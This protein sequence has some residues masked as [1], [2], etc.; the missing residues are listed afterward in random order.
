MR[1]TLKATLGI[2]LLVG[3]L[4]A[5]SLMA[6]ET[7]ASIRGVVVDISD[8]PVAN[9]KVELL[10]QRTG[11]LRTY[12]TN[13]E[14]V[15]LATRLSP[16]G[17][18]TVIV[19]DLATVSIESISVADTYN[20]KIN[21]DAITDVVTVTASRD[22]VE[23]ATGPAA[24]F[25][26]FEVETAVAFNRDIVDI[27]GIDPRIN[28][29]NE[30]DGFA[31]NCA[32]KHPRFN[33]VTLDGVSQ[34]DRFGLNENGYST[35][36]GMPFPYDAIG[37]L[38]VELAPADVTYGG[39]SAC[40]INAVTKS[41]TNEWRGNVFWDHTDDGL[42]GD[43][44][45]GSSN[46]F[47]TPPF[48]ADKYG[49]T[50]GGRIL[51]DKLHFFSALESNESPRF[52]ARGP[53][54]S[55]IGE[56][57]E[58][59]SQADH[60]RIVAIANDVY[61]YDP[62]GDPRDGAQEQDKYMV[63]FDWGI[64]PSHNA[65]L[66]YNYY[67]GFQDRDSDGDSNEF[68]FA[69]HFYVKGAKSETITAKLSSQ[70]GN[71]L[72]SEFFLSQNSM[73]D[74]QVTVGPGGFGD[75]QINI[76][77][78]V[79]YLG[80]DDSRQA[81]SL[82]TD[83]DYAK[84]SGQL[85]VGRSVFTAGYELE[86]TDIFNIF[87]QHSRGGEYD[88]FDDSGN[89]PAYC[90]GLT[91]Q[92]RFEDSSCALS[93]IDRFELGR[94]SR[95]YYGSGGGSND[96]NDAAAQFANSLHSVYVQDELFLDDHNLTIVAGLRYEF[97]TSSDQPNFNARFAEENNGLRNDSGLDGLSLLMPRLG[98]TWLPMARLSV[99]GSVG[100]YSG[101]NP[102]V[103][104]SNAW[105]NDG[106]T[107]VQLQLGNFGGSGSVLDGSIPLTG[108]RPGFDVPQELF[109]QVAAVTPANAS[110]SFLAL[111]D[112]DYKQPSEWKYSLGATY[113]FGSGY[114]VDFDYLHTELLDSA[115]YVD[116]SQD[117]VGTTRAGGPIYDYVRGRDNFM[118]TNSSFDAASDIL[119]LLVMKTWDWGL[120]M[121]IGYSH[122]D[123]EDISPMTSSTAGSNFDSTALIDI[124][125][126]RPA[127]SNYVV[128]ERFTLRASLGRDFFGDNETRF[129]IYAYTSAGQPQS[130]AMN[131]GDLEGDGFFGRHLLYVPTGTSDTNVVFA[132][133]FQTQEFFAWVE[134]EGLDSG[135]VSR[136]ARHA[137]WTS[138]LDFGVRQEFPVGFGLRGNFFIK[139]YNLLNFIDDDWG[140]VYDAPF[141][142]PEVVATD[143]NAE[144]QYVFT[145]FEEPDL[146][147]LIESRS[148]WEARWGV[149]LT[150]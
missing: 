66:I 67:D 111:I 71:S 117:I 52:L 7:T 148:L 34:G 102:N 108:N 105:S 45:G 85:L 41:G 68:E 30:D 20:L 5:P 50:F 110:N 54:G 144:G 76:N 26:S 82:N 93:G 89:N 11:N 61:G 116:V 80:A 127:T 37:Q 49:F 96:P 121:S 38:A 139:M 103:W 107:N 149:E 99:R 112:P 143:V 75:F 122:T 32:G 27:Y 133:S 40:T 19:N 51:Q 128:P 4:I 106:L 60:D 101:G 100:R 12:S 24:T 6:Q 131:G 53:A 15:F 44:L 92:G 10:D 48:D 39:F 35:A 145:D 42:R 31:I 95:I 87:V 146:S 130:F 3:G 86:K 124:N 74:S 62:G 129:T 56:E 81:N 22:F 98:V 114:Q 137:R 90:A 59:L 55:G 25:S 115:Y 63:R 14:G 141:F 28:V 65:A 1:I 113:R 135:F 147:E 78:D 142:V 58:W 94:P 18:Y 43:S 138:R 97:F 73:D 46:D 9:A 119:S 109:D 16:G 84:L 83:T 140:K 118:L 64:N 125:N 72:S 29:D 33:S 70:W 69:N 23:V 8:A 79:V 134:R 2:C 13:A 150:F 132:D 91:A 21:L 104:L 88:F 47:S 77:R 136:N 57:R 36:V 120:D 17:P 126:P 123:G